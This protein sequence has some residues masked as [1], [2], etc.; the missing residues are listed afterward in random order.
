[1][2]IFHFLSF[3]TLAAAADPLPEVVVTATR[4]ENAPKKIPAIVKTLDKKKIEERQPRTFPEALRELPGVAVQKTANGQ[5]SPFIRGFT[6]FRTLMMVDGIRYNNSTF[7]EGPNQYW[8]LLDPQAMERIEVIPSQ[9][10][11]LYGSDAIG[12]TVNTIS[13]SSGFGNEAAGGFFSHGLSSYRWSSAEH[14]HMEHL[15][16]SLGEG[17]KWG[18]HL[19]GTMGQFGDVKPGQGPRMRNTGYDQWAFDLR[20]DVALDDQWLLTAAHQQSRQNDVWR[21][22]STTSGVSFEGTAIGTDRVRSFDQA[23]SLS[24]VRLSGKDLGEWIDNARLT[25]SMQTQGEEQ[26]RVTGGGAESLNDVDLSTLGIDLQLESLTSLGRFVYGVDYYHDWVET[27]A[28]DNPIQGAVGDDSSYDLLGIFLQDNIDLG[29]RF[30]VTL[31]GRFTHARADVG[32]YR[33]PVTLTQQ[34]YS[35]EWQN[36]SGNLR[37]MLD[38]D[39]QDRFQLFGGISQ[40]FRSPNLSDLSRSDIALSGQLEVPSPGLSAET[41]L[42][43]E[44]GLKAQTE[45]LTASMAYFYTQIEDLIVRRATG[46]ANQVAK[47]NGGDGYMQGIEFSTNWQINPNW[48]V[49]GHVAWVEGEADQFIGLT[50]T[51]R[52]EPLGKISPLV[53]YGGVRWQTTSKKVWTEFVCLTYGEAARMNTGDQQDTQRIPP[54]GTPSFWLLTLRG[55]WQ[56][57]DHLILNAGVE[58]MLNQNY[59]YHGSGSNEPGVGVNLGA[60]VKF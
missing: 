23:R 34:S 14:S 12:G 39:E 28:T 46:I 56:V 52:R 55:G 27:D 16:A 47:A 2:R 18:L 24:Y 42:T 7:R 5:G 1:M 50:T 9:G 51:M 20:L 38:L 59:R 43:Y 36:F 41:Y 30:H 33:N 10:S 8:A 57:N 4:S 25:I 29:S 54:N 48:S 60:T 31:G 11:V 35:D 21:T 49:F 37:L 17:Q 13:K 15:E 58:N 3:A 19:G 22:H 26:L 6:G 40:A 44:I 53:G 32:K 45:T